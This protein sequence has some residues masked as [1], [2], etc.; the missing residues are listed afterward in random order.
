MNTVF[1]EI[2]MDLVKDINKITVPEGTNDDY[3]VDDII[4][5]GKFHVMS[6]TVSPKGRLLSVCLHG[7][8]RGFLVCINTSGGRLSVGDGEL[9]NDVT[10]YIS[11]RAC[12]AI[13]EYYCPSFARY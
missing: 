3:G 12:N 6:Y 9:G 10:V 11:D 4:D 7:I 5:N 13:N 2:A 8:I 1:K